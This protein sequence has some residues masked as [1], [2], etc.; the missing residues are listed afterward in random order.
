MSSTTAAV[1]A[2]REQ[3][4]PE[5][6]A[7]GAPATWHFVYKAAERF[8]VATMVMLAVLWYVRTDLIKPLLEAHYEFIDKIVDGQEAHTEEIKSV[9]QRLDEMIRIFK[10]DA[11]GMLPGRGE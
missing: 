6:V 11:K 1:Q 4:H 2:N 3:Q 5:E 10:T 9:N 7:A 8:G